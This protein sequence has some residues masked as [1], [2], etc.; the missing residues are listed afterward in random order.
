[1]RVCGCEISAQEVRLAVV[2]LNGER[3]VGL[4]RIRVRSAEKKWAFQN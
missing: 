4:L 2:E 1:M 3:N